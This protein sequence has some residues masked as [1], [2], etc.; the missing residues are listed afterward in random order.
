MNQLLVYL[1]LVD[2]P[3]APEVQVLL[4]LQ[5]QVMIHFY[6]FVFHIYIL[7]PIFC[8]ATTILKHH[9]LAFSLLSATDR[10]LTNSNG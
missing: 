2:I 10:L 9:F 1:I 8:S 7:L 5:Y 6:E 3:F 4:N